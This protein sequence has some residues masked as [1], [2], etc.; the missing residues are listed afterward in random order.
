[1]IAWSQRWL[2]TDFGWF[3]SQEIAVIYGA[4]DHIC[5]KEPKKEKEE[6]EAYY[7]WFYGVSIHYCLKSG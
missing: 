2:S 6:M 3:E 4:R 7:K 5:A 1:M